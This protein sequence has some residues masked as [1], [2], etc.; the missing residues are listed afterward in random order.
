M[1]DNPDQSAAFSNPD[2]SE[3]RSYVLFSILP[4]PLSTVSYIVRAYIRC[5]TGNENTM[6]DQWIMLYRTFQ[7]EKLSL[8]GFGTMR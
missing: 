3:D 1:P 4:C 8:L 7:G 2:K 5:Y 6:E